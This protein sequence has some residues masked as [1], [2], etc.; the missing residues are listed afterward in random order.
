MFKL[1][2]DIVN[3]VNK[4][5][6]LLGEYGALNLTEVFL[7]DVSVFFEMKIDTQCLF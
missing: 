1:I 4:I 7:F 5:E 3:S 2:C 6:W